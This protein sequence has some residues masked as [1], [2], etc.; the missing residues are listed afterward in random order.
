M[1][2]SLAQQPTLSSVDDYIE[3]PAEIDRR[4]K[5]RLLV[6]ASLL[7]LF[8]VSQ[9]VQLFNFLEG[10]Q[11]VKL[12]AV[13][14]AILF[15]SS[16]EQLV[17]RIRLRDAPQAKMIIAL[18]VIAALTIPFAVWPNVSLQYAANFYL[19]NVIFVYLLL[20]TVRSDKDVRT[21]ATVLAI[22]S[23]I[24]VIP[25][26]VHV[27]P[28]VTY[29][30]DPTR[31]AVGGTYDANDLALLFVVT[32]PFAFFALK[33][34]RP[35]VKAVLLVSLALMLAGMV[36]TGSRG[37]FLGLIAVGFMLFLGGSSQARKYTLI[38]VIA[39]T[40]LFVAAAPATYWDRIGTIY[41]YQSD[42]NL[43][44]AGG[45]IMIWKTGLKMI[46]QNPVIGIGI[47]CFPNEHA[48]LSEFHLQSAAHNAF[49]QITAELG[50]VGLLLFLGI[51]I[52]SL[53]VGR[54]VK[55]EVHA[56]RTDPDL[57]WLAAAVQASF[58]GYVTCAF[59]LSH[60]YSGIFSFCV[61]AAAILTARYRA[62]KRLSTPK[63]EIEYV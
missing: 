43:S 13:V 9:E 40:V 27:G 20:Q 62:H 58:V 29:K 4:R 39:G 12:T 57:L 21:I 16:R 63:Q 15:L 2:D 35:A 42:Y 60:A 51:I 7:T 11:I 47:G 33:G 61:A 50:I 10:L 49:L 59:F 8:F 24:Q 46:A 48:K 52:T 17:H 38:A 26:L 32:I 1:I 34:S 41:N 5:A 53:I 30:A 23:A 3:V 36:E 55:R 44:E 22:G 18:L 25:M 56:G 37:G 14:V 6:G 31:F 45:R 28:W 54:R 19:K